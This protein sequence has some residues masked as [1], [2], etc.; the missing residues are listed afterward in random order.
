MPDIPTRGT[1]GLSIAVVMLG[2]F[3]VSIG[4]IIRIGIQMIIKS[5]R[6]STVLRDHQKKIAQ[7]RK[8][9]LYNWKT[10]QAKREE[11]LVD[12]NAI[13]IGSPDSSLKGG[14]SVGGPKRRDRNQ[15]RQGEAAKLHEP[16]P[17]HE[18]MNSFSSGSEVTVD[19]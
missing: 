18:N 16:D 5:A 1:I 12:T 11:K 13:G 17:S 6:R 7:R 9:K 14:K 15:V 3:M 19:N 4:N 8:M 2:H 10:W